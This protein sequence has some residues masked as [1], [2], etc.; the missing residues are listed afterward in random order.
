M[1]YCDFAC[2]YTLSI[3]LLH[4]NMSVHDVKEMSKALLLLLLVLLAMV[5]AEGH[6]VQVA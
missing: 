6:Y 5:A 4:T 1:Y 2:V 3:L